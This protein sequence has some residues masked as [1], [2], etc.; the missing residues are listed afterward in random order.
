VNLAY[1][2]ERLLKGLGK[3]QILFFTESFKLAVVPDAFLRGLTSL[4][5][6]SFAGAATPTAPNMDD[7]TALQVVWWYGPAEGEGGHLSLSEAEY[8]TKFD[9]LVSCDF[10]TFTSQSLTRIPSLKNMRKLTMLVINSNK[11]TMVRSSDLAGA[12][13]L[14]QLQLF[15][16]VITSLNPTV[17]WSIVRCSFSPWILPC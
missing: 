2:P 14:E 3:L 4:Q 16:N 5:W 10:M 6:L 8:D 13:S 1:L 17:F 12:T 11:I 15:D 9:S 7:L